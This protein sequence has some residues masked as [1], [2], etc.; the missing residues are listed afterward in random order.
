MFK[1][2]PAVALFAAVIGA[3]PLVS[4]AADAQPPVA[5]ALPAQPAKTDVPVRRVVLYSSG[6]GYFEHHGTVTG[7]TS[8]ELRFKT[9]QI[10]DILKSLM[11]QDLDKGKINSITYPSQDPLAKLLRSFQVDVS[12]NLSRADLLKQLRGAK[13]TCMLQDGSSKSGIILGVETNKLPAPEKTQPAEISTLNLLTDQG[14]SYVDLP[15]INTI[16]F[17]DPRLQEEL[18]KALAA[19]ASA[20]DQ[21]KKS[22]SIQF[23]GEGTRRV[24]VGYVVET[25]VWKTSYRLVLD[26]AADAKP[27]IQGWAIVENQTDIDWNNVQLSLISGRPISFVQNLYQPLY[28]PRPIVEPELFASLRPSEYQGGMNAQNGEPMNAAAD[29]DN[30]SELGFAGDRAAAAHMAAKQRQLGVSRRGVN[31]PASP[32]AAKF[33]GSMEIAASVASAASA[34]KLGELF[35]YTVT[36]PVNLPRQQSAM[37]PIIADPI[38]A[39]R[40]SIY[41]AASLT[42]YPLNG[43]ILTNTTGKH[44]LN[45]PITVLDNGAYGGDARISDLPPG[46]QRLISYGIDLQ[47]LVDSTT[48]KNDASIQTAK[49]VKGVL[50]L[51]RKN[52]FTQEYRIENKAAKDKTLVIE[53]P[54]RAGW[55]LVSPD[56]AMETTDSIYRFQI[57]APAGKPTKLAV[58]EQN[59]QWETFAILP[60]DFDSLVFYSKN[61]EIPQKVRDALT[62]AA[63]LKQVIADTQHQ[64]EDTR[65]KIADASKAQQRTRDNM[66]VITAQAQ[67]NDYYTRQLKRLADQDAQL[68]TLQKTVDDQQQKLIVQQKE[69]EDYLNNLSVE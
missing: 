21:D 46:Q 56:K 64:I 34:S 50:N 33:D 19:L 62:R 10:N 4:L 52:V 67:A 27:F 47:V 41:N 51:A 59:T 49:I 24:K 37:L 42:R 48:Q 69:L 53:H 43:A 26:D 28:I 5:N 29:I 40:V 63:T 1:M 6:V 57:P 22:V 55:K 7:N 25:P 18:N 16:R 3:M 38:Q 9:A 8:T 39:Q 31:E 36:A 45:G 58:Q 44:L 35:E 32:A 68:D 15:G 54:F 60:F 11:L 66:K 2:I 14:V 65:T 17:E 61:G 30:K 20:R 23:S 12:N 13:V